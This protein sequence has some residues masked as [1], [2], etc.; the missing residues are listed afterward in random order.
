MPDGVFRAMI[1]RI[2][3]G[4]GKRVKD[5][6]ETLNTEIRNSI[7]EKKVSINEVRTMLDG[8]KRRMEKAEEQIMT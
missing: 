6:S 2:L 8:I 5:T 1:I 4:L 3:I 7:A